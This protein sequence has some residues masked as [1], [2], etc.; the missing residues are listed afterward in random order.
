MKNTEIR[1]DIISKL[2]TIEDEKKLKSIRAVINGM[3]DGE[4]RDKS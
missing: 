4:K 2:Q 1:Q 3:I